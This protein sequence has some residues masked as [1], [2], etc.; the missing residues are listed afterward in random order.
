MGGVDKVHPLP[1]M[2]VAADEDPEMLPASDMRNNLK[3]IES[4]WR[5]SQPTLVVGLAKGRMM[6]VKGPQ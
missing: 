3:L 1:V 4:D 5:W 2:I 6:F